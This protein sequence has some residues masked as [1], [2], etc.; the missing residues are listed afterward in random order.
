MSCIAPE[1]AFY[2]YPKL[3]IPDDDLTF[4][5]DLLAEKHVLLVHGSGFGQKKGTKHVRIVYLPDEPTLTR[6][7]EAMTDFMAKRYS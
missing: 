2:A 6:A 1:A 7:Y 3:D 5:K 4:V